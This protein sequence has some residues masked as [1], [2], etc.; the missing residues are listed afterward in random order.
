MLTLSSPSGSGI[1]GVAIGLN[2]LSHH[3]ACTV[4]WAFL[5][6]VVVALCAS[7]RKFHQIGWLTWAGFL[8]IFIAVLIVV[9]GVT[10]RDRPA[11]APPTGPYDL[12][13]SIIP[14]GIS[15]ASG[16]VASTTIFVSS[17]GTS[18]FLPVISEMRNPRDYRKALYVCMALVTSAYLA[19]SLVVYRWCGKWVA[20]PSL[21][22]AGQTVKMVAYGVGLI[23]LIVSACLYL[24]VA[25][26]YVFV[27]ILR[28]S[29]HLQANTLVHWATWLGC[30]FG[31]ASLSFMLAE[32]V[33]IFNYLISLTGSLCFA[34][35]AIALP[36]WLW[37]HDHKAW[38]RG[39]VVQRVV[40]WAH[41][42][43]IP[44]GV[45]FFIGGTYGVV[46]VIVAAYADGQ[47]GEFCVPGNTIFVDLMSVLLT[48]RY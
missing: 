43:L 18:A 8:S 37:I 4:W 20:S 1:L 28:N 13:Y 16:I 33:P 26:K 11:A 14:T 23:G 29:R 6:T 38:M 21:G 40:F 22:S 27:R 12:G 9:I 46:K 41:A 44:L 35:L 10:T 32:A 2:A 25:A 24:H 45:F 36:G 15:F 5:A 7:V 39:S 47:I 19:F 34:P 48:F 31:L 17:A 42:L 30:T 3:A